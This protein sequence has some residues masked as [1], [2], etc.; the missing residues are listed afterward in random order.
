MKI[1]SIF[2]KVLDNLI[3]SYFLKFWSA[4][5]IDVGIKW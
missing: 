1:R 2:T 5:K 3:A 4:M